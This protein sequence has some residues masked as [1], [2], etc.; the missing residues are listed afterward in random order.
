MKNWLPLSVWCAT[1]L[2]GCAAEPPRGGDAEDDGDGDGPAD[3]AIPLTAEGTYE[4]RSVFDLGTSL[5]GTAGAIA[6]Y[7]IEATDDPEDPTLFI[8]Q[9]VVAALPDGAI[10]SALRAA[11][12]LVAGALND[13]LLEVAPDF[14]STVVE[15][16]DA[17][18]Q[19]VHGLGTTERLE[20]ASTGA[21]IKTV[22]GLHVTID[23]L[24]HEL[25]FRDYALPETRIAGLAVTLSPAG[26][27]ALSDHRV[28]LRYGQL[29]RLALDEAILPWI[30]PSV[31][32]LG[33]LFGRI[34]SCAAVGALIYDAIGLGSASTFEAACTGGLNAGA[35]ALYAR[36]AG[37]DAVALELS[38][39]GAARGVDRDRDGK[40]DQILTGTYTGSV[41]YSGQPSPL[42]AARFSGARR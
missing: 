6:T 26:Q 10:K 31:T 17:L 20:I 12:P 11:T 42:G 3:P 33:E 8:V 18:G 32:H 21:A 29:L 40:L 30:D 35:A 28:P 9:R 1:I 38:L 37:I 22:T 36:M 41:R 13:R 34:V 14:V 19:V 15:V 27:L 23:N 4:V 25:A 16:G 24:T 39:A 5:P 7:F 2:A